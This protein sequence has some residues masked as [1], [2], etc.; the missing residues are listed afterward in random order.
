MALMLHSQAR[1]QD[2]RDMRSIRDNID[3]ALS[4]EMDRAEFLKAC[5][6]IVLA[7]VGITGVLK[8]LTA[9]QPKPSTAKPR[10]GAYGGRTFGG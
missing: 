7:A 3:R 6:I 1:K 4:A 8:A 9:S 10:A 2:A 5:G